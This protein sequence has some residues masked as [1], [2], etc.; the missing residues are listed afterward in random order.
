MGLLEWIEA[1]LEPE[2]V[3]DLA[4]ADADDMADNQVVRIWTFLLNAF[5]SNLSNK[6]V[7]GSYWR[8][9]SGSLLEVWQNIH[10]A[11][12]KLLV[13]QIFKQ[14]M[15]YEKQGSWSEVRSR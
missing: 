2:L 11:A 10:C 3:R 7:G 5:F 1:Q 6:L 8:Y 12:V 9:D 13:L 4:T 14:L 15:N